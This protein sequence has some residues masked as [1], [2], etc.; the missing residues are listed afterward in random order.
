MRN[1]VGI[2]DMPGF[3]KFRIEGSGAEAAL[4]RLVCTR[5]PH[6]HRIALSLALN[7]RGGIVSEFTITRL[8]PQSFY[9]V[10]AAA[11]ERHDAD[12]LR[13]SLPADGSVQ[14][15]S[16]TDRY[17]TLVI[18]GPHARDLL[19]RV[20]AA[21]LS[22]AAFP[23]LSARWIDLGSTSALA[24]RV[25][26]V[27]ELGWELHAPT[28]HLPGLYAALLAAGP[29]FGL[30]HFG[31]YAT[32]SMRL[33]KCYRAWK[34][35]LDTD[36]SPL[37]A[38]LDHRVAFDK[39]DFVGKDALWAQ[40]RQGVAR[41]L[42]PL[43]L[44]GPGTADAPAGGP[45]FAGTEWVGATTSGTW[46]HTLSRSLALAYLRADLA[47]PNSRV[48]VEVLGERCAATVGR[49]PL[50]DPDNERPRSGL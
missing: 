42:V 4:D 45:V 13:Q 15:E 2:M 22:N 8:G 6:L 27:G 44:D 38:S 26:Y 36:H 7:A 46:S 24:L 40:R 43:V 16:L 28:E 12:W 11:A 1:A 33:E 17:G 47:V 49:E 32:D 41:R 48:D 18:A 9:L 29:A 37:E 14:I 31:L 25:N 5:L 34:L 3:A 30:T 39:P 10:G 19:R 50:F 21:D 20:T 23:W 35:E